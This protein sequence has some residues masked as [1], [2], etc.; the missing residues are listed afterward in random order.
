MTLSSVWWP[1]VMSAAIL[2]SMLTSARFKRA[3]NV[4]LRC[5][6]CPQAVYGKVVQLCTN[7]KVEGWVVQA[8]SCKEYGM[9]R[10]NARPQKLRLQRCVQAQVLAWA[11]ILW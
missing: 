7:R 11:K 1:F 2:V 10:R 6:V 3:E 4:E 9:E 5:E 8:N